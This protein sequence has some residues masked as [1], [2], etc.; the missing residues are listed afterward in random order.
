MA[1]FFVPDDYEYA[2]SNFL[3]IKSPNLVRKTVPYAIKP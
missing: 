3:T 1:G 2:D